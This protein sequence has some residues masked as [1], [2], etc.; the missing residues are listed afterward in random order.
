VLRRI[1]KRSVPDLVGGD[2]MAGD[3]PVGRMFI[4]LVLLRQKLSPL[5]VTREAWLQQAEA[6]EQQLNAE[7]S[8]TRAVL[9]ISEAAPEIV[10]IDR[11]ATAFMMDHSAADILVAAFR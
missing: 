11:R 9:S 3:S 2:D 1:L 4:M 10:E 6:Y 7:Q 5:Y 8:Q